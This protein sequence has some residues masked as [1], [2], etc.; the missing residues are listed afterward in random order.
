MPHRDLPEHVRIAWTRLRHDLATHFDGPTVTFRRDG[1]DGW[2]EWEGTARGFRFDDETRSPQEIELDVV[3]LADI[4]CAQ[5]WPEGV[6]DP[7]PPCP[8]HRDH[9]L[10]PR[11]RRG[12]AVWSCL[13]DGSVSVEIGSL[14]SP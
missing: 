5:L 6:T 8:Q 10:Q 13:R 1:V 3:D 12:R 14:G 4:V 11:L 2:I 7:W 9:P